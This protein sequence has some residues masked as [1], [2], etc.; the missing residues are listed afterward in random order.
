MITRTLG[1]SG[2]EVFAIG[3]GCMGMSGSYGGRNDYEATE[4][5]MEA[6]ELGITYFDTADMYGQG[7]NE[8]L[9]GMNLKP[10]REKIHIGSKISREWDPETSAE[11]GIRNDPEYLRAACE[12]SLQR[13]QIECLDVLFLHRLDATRPV[14]ETIGCLDELRRAG[15]TRAIGLSEVSAETLRRCHAIAPI[16]VVQ[17]EYSLWSREPELAVIPTA[18]ELGIA[19][20]AFAPVGRGFLTGAA[21]AWLAMPESDYRR[22]L[23][24]FQPANAGANHNLLEQLQEIAAQRSCTSAQLSLAW[25]LAKHPHVLPIPGTRHVGHLRENVAAAGIELSDEEV[26]ILD[27]AFPIGAA[28]GARYPDSDLKIVGV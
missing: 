13:L 21:P 18:R 14:E 23:P 19:F 10:Y 16:D 6:I 28:S 20:M 3:L 17:S 24:R 1:Q 8:T 25:I 5:L 15:K 22:Q 9:L 27:A 2:I 11:L 12:A 4:T 26:A 7:H